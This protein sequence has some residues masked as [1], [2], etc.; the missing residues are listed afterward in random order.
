M[1]KFTKYPSGLCKANSDAGRSYTEYA[2]EVYQITDDYRG[3][4]FLY[5]LDIYD[6][7]EEA[8]TYC[9]SNPLSEPDEFYVIR[10]ISYENGEEVETGRYEEL[11]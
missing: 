7:P 9:D 10:Y 6:T 2:V 8:H 11:R 1:R 3:D 4:R 5:Q